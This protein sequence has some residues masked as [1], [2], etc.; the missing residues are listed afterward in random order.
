MTLQ[1]LKR[2]GLGLLALAVLTAASATAQDASTAVAVDVEIAGV[3]T[4]TG[5]IRAAL[6]PDGGWSQR[7]VNAVNIPVGPETV[8]F[9]MTAPAPG[10][11]AVRLFHDVDGDG[12]MNAN[13]MGIPTEPF[14]T[15]NDAP[16]RFG[17]PAFE[18][19][20]FEV[21]PDGAVQIITLQG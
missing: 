16:P 4:R 12:E 20:V 21:G 3:E 13:L 19:A 2:A 7:P 11:Y 14:G 1:P 18:D 17:P 9:Q 6:Y 10:R 5:Y 8:R 15:S